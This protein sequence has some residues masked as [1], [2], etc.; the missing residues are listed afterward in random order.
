MQCEQGKYFGKCCWQV[1]LLVAS[2]G[3]DFLHAAFQGCNYMIVN[4]AY[5]C[6][7]ITLCIGEDMVLIGEFILLNSV[8][9]Q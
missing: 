4:D 8:T 6:S 9:A 2:I 7:N 5:N 3:Q 1:S